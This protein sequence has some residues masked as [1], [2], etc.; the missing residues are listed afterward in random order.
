MNYTFYL[1]LYLPSYFE[2]FETNNLFSCFSL[3]PLHTLADTQIH[4]YCLYVYTKFLYN[5]IITKA[6]VTK[7]TTLM[8]AW[9]PRI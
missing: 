2:T 6:M 1:T 7:V 4:M 8:V 9:F 3:F 5:S